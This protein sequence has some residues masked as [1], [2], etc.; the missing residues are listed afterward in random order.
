MTGPGWDTIIADAVTAIEKHAVDAGLKDFAI[1]QIK[2]KFG[3][4]RIYTSV[5]DDAIDGIVTTAE[6]RA[7]VTCEVCGAPGRMRDGGW[8]KT[9]CDDCEAKR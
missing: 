4:L 5:T 7:A 2:E 6:K 8:L 3:G 9:L 1:V